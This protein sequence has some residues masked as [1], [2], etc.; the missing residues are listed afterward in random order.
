MNLRSHTAWLFGIALTVGSFGLGDGKA[1]AQ[2]SYNFSITYTTEF[3]FPPLDPDLLPQDVDISQLI[4]N[5]PPEFQQGLPENLPPVLVNPQ[6]LD[7]SGVGESINPNPPFGLTNFT[8]KTFGLSLP[9][10][11]NTQN[12]IPARQV[13]IFRAYPADVNVNL[14]SPALSDVYFGEGTN[15]RLIG[16]ANDQAIFDFEAGTIAGGGIITIVGGEGIF[17]GA[18]GQINFSQRDVLGPPDAPSIGQAR[19]DFAVQVPQAVPEPST[20]ATLAGIGVI[21]TLFLLRRHR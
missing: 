8:T 17:E 7:V 18:S 14:P 9:P 6:I 16:L 11:V 21:G 20:N 1:I 4:Q 12:G 13:A 3:T 2:T 10:K 19:L 15:N 5:L